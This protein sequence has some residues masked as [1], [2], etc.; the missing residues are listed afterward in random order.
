METKT[1]ENFLT[2][3]WN[4]WLT[5]GFGIPILVYAYIVF[6]TL[7]LSDFAGFIG[8]FVFGAVY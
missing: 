3:N 8:M 2:K 5:L 6:Y 1:K 7:L 4:N